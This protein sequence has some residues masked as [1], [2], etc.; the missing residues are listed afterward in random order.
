MRWGIAAPLLGTCALAAGAAHAT[1]QCPTTTLEG[2]DVPV[3]SGTIDW[4]SVAGSGRKFAFLKL[5]QGNYLIETQ[6]P[7]NWTGVGAA[8]MLRSAFHFFDPTIDGA[9]QAHYFLSALAAQGGPVA[10][11]LPPMLD[12][13]CPSSSNEAGATPNCEKMGDS[14]WV[15]SATL[16]QRVFDWL[17]AVEQATGTKPIIYSYPAWFADVGFTDARLAQYPL[18]VTSTSQASCVTVPSPWTAATFWQYSFNGTVPGIAGSTTDLDRFLGTQTQLGA[19]VE[20]AR[21]A[22]SDGAAATDAEAG[23]DDDAGA[24]SDAGAGGGGAGADAGAPAGA[25]GSGSGCSCHEGGDTSGGALGFGWAAVAAVAA[26]ATWSARRTKRR[27][28]VRP[29]HR[30]S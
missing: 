7:T 30:R 3:Y 1:T 24:T 6:F 27:K 4:T 20:T 12:L 25:T 16:A 11:D 14:G 23:I 21:D 9:L 22:G 29:A 15:D 17:N 5:T 28:H 18:F 2:V 13:E 19:L 10:G 8:G 26:V